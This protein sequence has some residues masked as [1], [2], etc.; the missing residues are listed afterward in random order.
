MLCAHIKWLQLD[1]PSLLHHLGYSTVTNYEQSP[2][3]LSQPLR[4]A[5]LPAAWLGGRR[6][7]E[8][9][10]CIYDAVVVR[11][12]AVLLL[13]GALRTAALATWAQQPAQPQKWWRYICK[14]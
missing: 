7:Y 6:V 3:W 8:Q 13:F 14:W 12:E 2:S 9:V 11:P 1:V 5:S 10:V 4:L